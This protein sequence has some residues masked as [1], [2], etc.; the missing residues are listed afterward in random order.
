VAP[1]DR[2][3]K[4]EG[5]R[6]KRDEAARPGKRTRFDDVGGSAEAATE[7]Q[8]S[9][10]EAERFSSLPERS[11]APPIR[12]RVDDGGQPFI[13]CRV[14]RYDNPVGARVCCF[15]EAD[16]TTPAQRSFNEALWDRTLEERAEYKQEAERIAAA[17]QATDAQYVRAM[18]EL[19]RLRLGQIRWSDGGQ[20]YPFADR[21]AA[22]GRAIARWLVR[23]F[24]DRRRRLFVLGGAL[25][26]MNVLT[27][28]WV[29]GRGRGL[30]LWWASV[31]IQVVSLLSAW[32]RVRG[33]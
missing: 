25:V 20:L 10:G 2:F 3:L 18:R 9:G 12:V 22:V 26:L 30:T 15:C 33:G 14:C 5:R 31:L 29:Q 23:T 6:P 8:R 17:Q 4:I 19:Q 28:W 7:P 13:R 21:F 1:L 11:D 16:L 32:V 24:P 27:L